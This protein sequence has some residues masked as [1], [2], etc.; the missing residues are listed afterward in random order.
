MA[1]EGLD[2]ALK[3]EKKKQGDNTAVIADVIFPKEG[4]IRCGI[5]FELENTKTDKSVRTIKQMDIEFLD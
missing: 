3:I 2:Y 4:S 1:N 5:S